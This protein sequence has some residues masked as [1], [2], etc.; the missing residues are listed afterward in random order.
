MRKW[1]IFSLSVFLLLGCDPESKTKAEICNDG[2]DNDGDGHVDCADPGCYGQAGG[3]TGQ[4]C[5]S[6]ESRCD[7]AFDNDADGDTDCA[8]SDC[9]ASCGGVED[10]DDGTDNDGD[11][12]VDCDDADCDEDPACTGG[13]ICDNDLDD[14][15]DGDVDCDDADCAAAV[16]CNPVED[17]DDGIDN[18]GDTFADCADSDCLGQQGAGGLC[19]AT[20]AACNDGFDNDADGDTDCADD[21]CASAANCQGPVE[22]CDVAGDEDGDG[23]ADCR[24]PECNNQTGPGGGSCQTVETSC[25]DSYDNDGDGLTDCADSD[26]TA[27]CLTA[28]SLVITEIMKDPNVVADNAGEWFEVQNT[29]ANAINLQGLVIYSTASGGDET[30]VIASSVSVP[31]G[32]RAVLGL[33]AD[34]GLN[35]GVTVNYVYTGI[36]FNNTADDRVGLRTA[37]GTVID[38]VSFPVATFPGFAGWA[39]QLDAGNL[40][41]LANDS[42]ANWCSSRVKYNAFDTGTPGAANHLCAVET[43]CADSLDND[44]DGAVDCADFACANAATCSTAAVP[45]AGSLIVTELMANPGVG[46]PNYQHEWFEVLNTT[47]GPVELN[48]LTICDDTPTRY[49]F[50]VHFGVS[51][52]LAADAR[53]IFVSDDSLWTGHAGILFEYG[54]AIQLATAADAVQIF[55]GSTLIDAVVYDAAWP[56]ATAGAAVQ[57]SSSAAQTAA[58]NDLLADWC[59]ALAE[60]DAVNHLY[61]TPGAANR[62]CHLAETVCNDNTDNDGDGRIDCADADCVGQTGALGELC[63]AT[64]STCDDGFDNDRDGLTDCA[65]P[66]CAGLPGPG[67]A[68]CPSGSMTLFFSEYLEGNSNNKAFEIYNPFATAYDLS[69]CQVKLYANGTSTATSTANLSGMLAAGDVYVVC[70]A[71]SIAGILAVCDLQHGT[72]NFNG[73]DALELICGGVTVDVIG[74][75]GFDPGSEWIVGGVSTLNQTLRRKCG[76]TDG[77][78]VRDDAFDP[79]VEWNTFPI[80]TIDGLGSHT[81]TCK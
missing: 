7:D 18:D 67:G 15:D 60:Y 62:D 40:T 52:P 1:F 69:Q 77:D 3:P 57:Y 13:E 24:D 33:S 63:Q 12:D 20:E 8:D 9:A 22:D 49:C 80:D 55:H 65:D 14:D 47:A 4:L 46:T 32:G 21:D 6:T 50:R 78:S 16:N 41:A 53:A 5:Q 48:G 23:L 37:G 25:A 42:A 68:N 79:S 39:M 71:S 81:V 76:I 28:G 35:G 44:G 31:A 36:A 66:N 26:C 30:H 51:T 17:C 64:E 70:N 29:S 43:A 74:Q 72:A 73:D 10:C 61:G 34:P 2:I 27:E 56:F 59:L 45:V 75:V 38:E 11:G 19:Q 58:A 54:P